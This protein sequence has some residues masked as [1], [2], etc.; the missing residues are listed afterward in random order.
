VGVQDFTRAAKLNRLELNYQ[1]Q[2]YILK[3]DMEPFT[4]GRNTGVSSLL[5]SNSFASRDHCQIIFRREKFIFCDTSTNGSYV[6]QYNQSEIYL[7]REELPLSGQGIV[8][9]SQPASQAGD[10]VIKYSLNI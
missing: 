7:R 5:T 4:I 1:N 9:I 6:T 2:R 10:E 3:T 8:S